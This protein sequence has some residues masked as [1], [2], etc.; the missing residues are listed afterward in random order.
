MLYTHAVPSTLTSLPHLSSRLVSTASSC[1]SLK[2]G[3][4]SCSALEHCANDATTL[5]SKNNN[6]ASRLDDSMHDLFRTCNQDAL[7]TTTSVSSRD[8]TQLNRTA[9]SSAA[10]PVFR[11]WDRW[12][13]KSVSNKDLLG[14]K[15]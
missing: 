2:R 12:N 11:S 9:Q 13:G 7:R 8:I 3:N 10:V 4:W 14:C 1:S 5:N 6:G 15:A